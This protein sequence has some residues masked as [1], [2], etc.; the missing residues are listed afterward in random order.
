MA[1]LAVVSTDQ[2]AP[3]ERIPYWKD[4]IWQQL[5]RLRS[6]ARSDGV[7]RGSLTYCDAGD[8]KL[9][10]L[11]ASSHRVARTPDL[12]RQDDRG[13]LKVVFQLEG[14]TWFEQGSR[15][16]LLAPGEWSIYD[17]MKAYTVSNTSDIE[18]LV[19]LVPREKVFAAGMRPED[20][21]V[22]RY[23]A[24]TGIGRLA[25]D[26][27]HRAFEEIEECSSDS[28]E[29]IGDAIA[30]LLRQSLMERAGR[31]TSLSLREALRDRIK[32]HVHR[33]LRDPALS[34][35]RIAAALRC[36]KRTL[37]KAFSNDG[38]TLSEYIWRLRL[39]RCR[40]DLESPACAW[41]SITEIAFSWG[42]SSPAHFSKAFRD[43]FGV[44]PKQFRL[45]AG[46]PDALATHETQDA[47]TLAL[48]V[49]REGVG[50]H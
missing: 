9:C 5:G 33:N 44:A 28:A 48:D 3:K 27:M 47:G 32:Q 20:L 29:T 49:M 22:Q 8:V 2:V 16:T 4:V 25:G 38:L 13:F 23:S 30:Q 35:D 39:N 19:L 15:K 1:A 41:K 24:Q 18:Q 43:A 40:R 11:S 37:H 14:S 26:L 12:I 42:F 36:S 31:P 46:T 21:L 10:R 17:T 45:A 50:P 7:F 6:D 34:I